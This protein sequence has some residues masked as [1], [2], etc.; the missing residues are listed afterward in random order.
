MSNKPKIKPT[1]KFLIK[2]QDGT[3]FH[4]TSKEI[5]YGVGDNSLFNDVVRFAYEDI[6]SEKILGTLRKFCGITVQLDL[7]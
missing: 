4:A 5:E 2:T 6:K 7:V 1:S 3:S